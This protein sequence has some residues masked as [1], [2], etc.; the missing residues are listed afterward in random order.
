MRQ[1]EMAY[2]S[3]GRNE[4]FV[5]GRATLFLFALSQFALEGENWKVTETFSFFF[6][7][8]ERLWVG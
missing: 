4:M 5:C 7:G 6:A 8:E 1:S 3:T 2:I